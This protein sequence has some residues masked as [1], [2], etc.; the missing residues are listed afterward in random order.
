M[1]FLGHSLELWGVV[2]LAT[3]TKLRATH[4]LGFRSAVG[5]SIIAIASAILFYEPVMVL[6]GLSSSW[7]LIIAG[8][9]ALTFEDVMQSVI[10]M[11][12]DSSFFKELVKLI[13]KK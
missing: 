6:L 13:I 10:S 2:A 12:K 3:F 7:E 4:K 8:L 11:S 9:I 1:Q 5:I